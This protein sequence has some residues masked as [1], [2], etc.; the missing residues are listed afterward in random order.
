M[1]LELRNK[2]ARRKLGGKQMEGI[3]MLKRQDVGR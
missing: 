2:R 1:K 3:D